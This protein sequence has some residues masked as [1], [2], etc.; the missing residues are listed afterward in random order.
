M[1]F[2]WLPE[3]FFCFLFFLLWCKLHQSRRLSCMFCWTF[4][5]TGNGY[6]LMWLSWVEAGVACFK[7]LHVIEPCRLLCCVKHEE[8]PAYCL[9]LCIC[10]QVSVEY[11]ADLHSS[12]HGSGFPLGEFEEESHKVRKQLVVLL[13]LAGL[14]VFVM[15]ICFVRD[16]VCEWE[17]GL[18][19]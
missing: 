19:W 12:E 5:D 8:V 11:G 7:W 16:F 18:C 13:S 3:R 2:D 6:I 14:L 4:M 1:P 10:Y 17:F 9:L 15:W